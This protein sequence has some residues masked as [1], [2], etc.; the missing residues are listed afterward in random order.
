LSVLLSGQPDLVRVTLIGA[1]VAALAVA[2]WTLAA[3]LP[4]WIALWMQAADNKK[5]VRYD[6]IQRAPKQARD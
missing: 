3:Q 1:S 4:L 2:L 5:K 6:S